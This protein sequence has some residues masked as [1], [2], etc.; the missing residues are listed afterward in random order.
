[1]RGDVKA[2]RSSSGRCDLSDFCREFCLTLP[3]L[4]HYIFSHFPH[5]SHVLCC[6][7]TSGVALRAGK[8]VPDV[9]C[10]GCGRPQRAHERH[11]QPPHTRGL[12]HHRG[13]AAVRTT[14][15]PRS[16]PSTAAGLDLHCL[17]ERAGKNRSAPSCRLTPRL[18]GTLVISPCDSTHL[19]EQCHGS[20]RLHSGGPHH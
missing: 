14:S 2:R 19:T 13:G 15:G 10:H 7:N 17:D 6:R 8:A 20:L 16:P 18:C 12:W 9:E 1:M 11:Q 5:F 3:Q 4:S